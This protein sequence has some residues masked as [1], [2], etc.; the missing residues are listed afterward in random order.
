MLNQRQDVKQ[1][2]NLCELGRKHRP[3][4]RQ[5]WSH[6]LRIESSEASPP[7]PLHK[8]LYTMEYHEQKTQSK[9]IHS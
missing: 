7:C 2:Q 6:D 1:I 4:M 8:I 9:D 5:I 3:V